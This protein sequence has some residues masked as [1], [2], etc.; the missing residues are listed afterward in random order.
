MP[1]WSERRRCFQRLSL[2]SA[3][4]VVTSESWGVWFDHLFAGRTADPLIDGGIRASRMGDSCGP[5]PADPDT[6]GSLCSRSD[7]K[8]SHKNMSVSPPL[9]PS[10]FLRLGTIFAV[11]NAHDVRSVVE[12]GPGLGAT[13]WRIAQG[14]RYVGY[15]PDPTSFQVLATR[16]DGVPDIELHNSTPPQIPSE[17]FDALVAFE[18]LEHIE[19]DVAALAGWVQWVRPGGVVLLTVPGHQR[20]FGPMDVAAG[21]YR[22]YERRELEEK[23]RGAGLEHVVIKAYGMP[24]GYLLEWVRNRLLVR[25]LDGVDLE[26]STA[27]SG[28]VFQPTRGGL[29][30]RIVMTPFAWLQ[31]PF[32]DTELGTSWVAWG[33]RPS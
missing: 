31:K 32:G 6:R 28:R 20:R 13:S 23:L 10:A 9:S 29:L 8:T 12:V 5:R 14:R 30:I 21:H 19:R 17:E 16:L 2:T 3:S 4:L 15:E 33:Q 22:R 27:R 1:T 24:A 18:V 11:L 25:R 26:G 7:P